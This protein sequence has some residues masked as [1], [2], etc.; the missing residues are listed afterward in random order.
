[1]LDDFGH[2][3]YNNHLNVYLQFACFFSRIL[4]WQ[5]AY[6]NTSNITQSARLFFFVRSLA[7]C[8]SSEGRSTPE[9]VA[10]VPPAGLYIGPPVAAKACKCW[11]NNFR[12]LLKHPSMGAMYNIEPYE[13]I[14][15][16]F[17][18]WL[19]CFNKKKGD[20]KLVLRQ[21]LQQLLPRR[22]GTDC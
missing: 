2:I 17:G 4:S 15:W 12:R 14:E 21:C 22:G 19:L 9:P 10:E 6:W 7:I 20:A 1:M 16:R 11:W 8:E 18:R 5:I 3:V 13:H